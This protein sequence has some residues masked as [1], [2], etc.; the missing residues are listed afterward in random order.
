MISLVGHREGT[1]GWI[2][3]EVDQIDAAAAAG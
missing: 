1:C 3:R 2:L